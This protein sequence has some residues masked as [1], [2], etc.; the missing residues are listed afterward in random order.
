MNKL[1]WLSFSGPEGWRGGCF[2][3]AEDE[4]GAIVESH[5]LK[6]NP[7]GEVLIVPAP[8]GCAL[9]PES[10]MN[11]LLTRAELDE[12]GPSKSLKELRAEKESV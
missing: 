7:H 1:W 2:V 11:R 10:H 3:L 9:P 5:R 4:L 6:I 8:D 12:L